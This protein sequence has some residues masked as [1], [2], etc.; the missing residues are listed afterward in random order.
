MEFAKLHKMVLTAL[1]T[2]LVIAGA[3][4][5]FPLPF[6]PVPIVLQNLFVLAAGLVLGWRWAAISILLYLLLGV[7][8]L[9]VFSAA[10]GG[11]AHLFGPTGG[12]LIGFLAAAIV[13][14]LLSH[15][16]RPR[17]ATDVIAV[18]AGTIAIYLFGVPWLKVQADMTWTA[19]LAAG[20]T[21]FLVGDA[22]KAAAAVA[23]AG[24]ARS[25]VAPFQPQTQ[26][27]QPD[28]RV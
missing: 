10:R 8:G 20:L 15:L 16:G 28:A 18:V 7:V 17:I 1:F 6:S 21:P 13:S 23:V 5:S 19:A 24:A 25:A 3:Y 2:A 9:P 14:G 27:E 22:L 12:Y 26:P 4:I 11:L